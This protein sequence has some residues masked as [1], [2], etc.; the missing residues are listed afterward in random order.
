MPLPDGGGFE[1]CEDTS[2]RR[3]ESTACPSVLPRSEPVSGAVYDECVY[4]ADCTESANGYC[5][6][7]ACYYGCTIDAECGTGAMCFCGPVIGSCV[8]AGCRNDADCA[9]DYPC[10]GNPLT[11]AGKPDF[12]CQTPTDNC[13]TD[14]DCKPVHPRVHCV[15]NGTRRI[16]II[17]RVG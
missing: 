9:P 2:L 16:C 5:V 3:H 14:A 17:D 12:V 6:I 15:S 10:T 13:Q 11:G 8:A 7:G 1:V 4:D